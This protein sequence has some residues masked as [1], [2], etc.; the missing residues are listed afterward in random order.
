MGSTSNMLG[1][2]GAYYLCLP[3]TPKYNKKI[4]GNIGN[5][6][7]I[8]NTLLDLSGYHDSI[9]IN[10]STPGFHQALCAVCQVTYRSNAIMLPGTIYCPSGWTREYQGYIMAQILGK[11]RTQFSCVDKNPDIQEKTTELI[12]VLTSLNFVE[13]K[14][15]AVSCMATNYVKYAEMA[16]VVCSK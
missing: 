15:T 16:C 5:S 10:T 6:S 1:S 4:D 2:N 13:S 11:K 8:Y 3:E 9:M 12:R 14:C 7:Y